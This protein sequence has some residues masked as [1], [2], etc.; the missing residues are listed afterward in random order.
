MEGETAMKDEL[1]LKIE[2]RFLA[3]R[4][5]L[6]RLCVNTEYT[7]RAFYER[8][9]LRPVPMCGCWH[10]TIRFLIIRSPLRGLI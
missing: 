10:I 5:D 9:R 4:F 7:P 3:N 2:D 1:N 6:S 8:S